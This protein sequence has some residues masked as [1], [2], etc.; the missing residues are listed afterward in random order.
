MAKKRL[1]KKPQPTPGLEII[2]PLGEALRRI[3]QLEAERE[4]MFAAFDKAKA[5]LEQIRE[6]TRQQIEEAKRGLTPEDLEKARKA[7]GEDLT[8]E[9]RKWQGELVNISKRVLQGPRTT[10]IP[11]TDDL[12][13]YAGMVWS[14]RAGVQGQWPVEVWDVYLNRQRGLQEYQRTKEMLGAAKTAAGIRPIKI[15]DYDKPLR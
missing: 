5:D 8:S 13:P 1:R 7:A 4:Q 2:D 14:F 11:W 3:E 6:E 12:I 9:I 15:A 10:E